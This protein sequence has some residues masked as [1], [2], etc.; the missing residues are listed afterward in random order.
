MCDEEGASLT[1]RVRRGTGYPALEHAADEF[2]V[3]GDLIEPQFKFLGG[4]LVFGPAKPDRVELGQE[5]GLV[6][7]AAVLGGGR[8]GERGMFDTVQK[9]LRFV[10]RVVP[11]PLE[12]E[13]LL[14]FYWLGCALRIVVGIRPIAGAFW[15]IAVVSA[16]APEIQGRWLL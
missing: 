11:Q 14:F 9:E 13:P 3:N 16:Y 6:R 12:A 2:F 5:E 10:C 15:L 4:V 8:C 1:S 7:V